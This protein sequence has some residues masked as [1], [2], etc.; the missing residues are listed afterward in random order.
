MPPRAPLAPHLEAGHR[1]RRHLEVVDVDAGGVE[2]DHDRPLQGPR[3]TRLES[4]DVVTVE[5]FLSVVP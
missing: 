5:P 3:A 4:R 1:D 2:P